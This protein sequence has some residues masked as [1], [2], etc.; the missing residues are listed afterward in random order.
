MNV[1]ILNSNYGNDSKPVEPGTNK[2]KYINKVTL[3]FKREELLYDCKNIAYVEGDVMPTNDEHD[4]H[5]V[6]DIAE[7]G[8]IDRVSRVIGVAIADVREMLFPY[9]KEEIKDVESTDDTL[10]SPDQYTIEMKVPKDFSKTTIDL[11]AKYIHEYIVYQVLKDWMSIT[12]LKNQGSS[13]NWA[14]KAQEM[15]DQIESTLN[16]RRY[17]V[18]R[19]LSPF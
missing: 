8:N 6:M 14:E 9:T 15:K 5:Q 3:T 13:R 2:L 12:N 18:R 1:I 17:R 19:T 11:L 4:R 7:D 16:A 10:E